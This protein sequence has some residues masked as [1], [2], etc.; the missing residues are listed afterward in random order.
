MQGWKAAFITA[1]NLAACFKCKLTDVWDMVLKFVIMKLNK[2]SAMGNLLSEL[3]FLASI[4]IDSP[5]VRCAVWTP[6]VRNRQVK[7]VTVLPST[8]A[9]CNKQLTT[10][11]M[12]FNKIVH[13][14]IKHFV[15]QWGHRPSIRFWD[16]EALEWSSSSRSIYIFKS[17]NPG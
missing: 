17:L 11:M 10:K 2:R 9:K 3:K 5:S 8:L 12:L 6:Q 14:R 13:S 7:K 1:V 15:P 16:P 4:L